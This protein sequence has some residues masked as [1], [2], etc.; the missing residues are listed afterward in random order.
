LGVADPR[1][2]VGAAWFDFDQDGD[3]DLYVTNMD[4]DPNGLFRN[5]RSRFVDVAE[6]LGVDSGGRPLGLSSHGSV[7]PSLVDF[8]SDGDI[9]IFLANYGPNGLYENESGA[10]F[11]NVAAKLGL[12]ID[13]RYDTGTWGDYNNDGHLDLYVNGTVSGGKNYP[14]YLFQN[15]GERFIDVTPEILGK[16]EADHGAHWADCDN[17]G[18]LDLALTGAG[19]HYVLE[20]LLPE[21]RAQRSLQVMVLDAQGRYTLAGSEIRL[22]RSGTKELLGMNILDTGSGYNSQNA[23]PVHFGVPA[24]GLVDVEITTFSKKGRKATMLPNVDPKDYTGRWLTVK[25]SREGGVVE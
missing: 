21:E 2:T 19:M 1:R 10:A 5:D 17:D 13:G 3:L 23:M 16:L 6:E 24:G 9:D 14:D 11:T 8:D 15:D 22:Y 18:D 4:G 20:N 7:R 12:A 25:V